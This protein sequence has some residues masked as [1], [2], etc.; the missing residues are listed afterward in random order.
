MLRAV[1]FDFDG[2]MLDTERAEFDSWR[3]VYRDHGTELDFGAYEACIGTAGAF[4]PVGHLERLTGRSVDRS[5]VTEDFK[6]RQ[7]RRISGMNW[8]PGVTARI[9]EAG[10]LGLKLAIASSSL[11]EWVAGHLRERGFERMFDAIA[12]RDDRL[13]A[14]PHPDIY[15]EALRLLGVEAG[16]AVAFEDSMNGVNAAKAA[17]LLCVAVPNGLTKDMD[18]SAADLR[19]GSLEEVSLTALAG[20]AGKGR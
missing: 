3:E 1:I 15:L 16:E 12:N 5:A 11:R 19:V 2:L 14:K 10:G 18:L 20:A 17:G 8:L 9:D 4:D 13:R 6:A 7:A